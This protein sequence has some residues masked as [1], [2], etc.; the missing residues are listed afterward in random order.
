MSTISLR[1]PESLHKKV[2]ELAKSEGVSINQLITTALAEKMSALMTVDYLQERA[3]RGDRAK[4]ERAMGK[5]ADV[6]P[7]EAD[8]RPAAD[9]FLSWQL[10]GAASLETSESRSG[11]GRDGRD[12][13]RPNLPAI[14][15]AEGTSSPNP[16]PMGR[17]K[18][19]RP[20]A[21]PAPTL[22]R[23]TAWA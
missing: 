17:A 9:A 19:P 3:A 21:T 1:L 6:E 15:D 18:P 13:R 4:F 2:R 20:C 11:H 22:V 14:R 23:R 5:V 12:P 7:D 10:S 16:T 8:R